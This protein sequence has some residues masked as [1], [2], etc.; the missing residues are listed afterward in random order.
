MSEM[1]LSKE[2]ELPLSDKFSYL[3]EGRGVPLLKDEHFR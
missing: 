3:L 2:R 1:M